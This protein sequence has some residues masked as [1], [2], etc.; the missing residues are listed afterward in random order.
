MKRGGS[1]ALWLAFIPSRAL[2]Q[3]VGRRFA[4][5]HSV[6]AG[7]IGFRPAREFRFSAVC[8]L[9][10]ATQLEVRRENLHAQGPEFYSRALINFN[11]RRSLQK[12]LIK[13]LTQI[14]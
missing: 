5:V 3:V 14:T 9:F 2:R 4:L 10:H 13:I 1:L 6:A 8:F 7:K 11:E 12:L